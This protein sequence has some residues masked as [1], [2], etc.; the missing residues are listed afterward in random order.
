MI[1]KAHLLAFADGAVRNVTVPDEEIA[2]ADQSAKLER[3]FYYGQNDFACQEDLDQRLPSLSAG[4]VVELEDGTLV[5][6]KAAGWE[7][8]SEGTDVATLPRGWEA[9]RKSWAGL[10]EALA[11]PEQK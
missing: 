10:R 8:L 2:G 6:C 1:F 7:V 3:I 5:F 4:D 9:T 11:K